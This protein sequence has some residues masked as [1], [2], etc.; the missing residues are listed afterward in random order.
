[1]N[2]ICSTSKEGSGTQTN[3]AEPMG[4]RGRRVAGQGR[5]RAGSGDRRCCFGS[6]RGEG[7]DEGKGLGS[8]QDPRRHGE[9]LG[10]LTWREAEVGG[11]GRG[12]GQGSASMLGYRGRGENENYSR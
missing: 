2:E 1:M 7:G 6:G 3:L 9:G 11:V 4:R 10:F 5:E 12:I 8:G